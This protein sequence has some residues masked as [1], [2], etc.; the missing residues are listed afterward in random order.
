MPIGDQTFDVCLSIGGP[1][2]IGGHDLDS[3]MHELARVL[4]PG[5]FVVL[6]D[7]FRDEC[8][9]NPWLRVD[10]PDALGW[11]QLLEAAGMSVVFFE[12]FVAAAWDE[13]LE[14]MSELVA[15]ARRDSW[16]DLETMAWA[17]E[18]EREIAT[19]RPNGPWANYGTFVAQKA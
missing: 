5:G 16:D 9:P 14:P 4:K 19:D 17:D 1:S 11:W 15:E 18:V 8:D 13:Y 2:C 6:S 3:V 10:H 7:M 12:H